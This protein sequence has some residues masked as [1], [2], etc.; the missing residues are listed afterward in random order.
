MTELNRNKAFKTRLLTG[1]AMLLPGVA[2]PLAARIAEDLNFEAL[3]VTGAGVSNTNFGLPD[4]GLTGLTDVANAVICIRSVV[5]LPLVVDAD[6]GFGN[7]VNVYH[8]VRTLEAAGANAIQLEDQDFPKRCGHFEGKSVIASSL[9]VDKIKAAVDARWDSDLQIVART[10]A[11]AVEG[12]EAAIERAQ[13]Y[14]EAG[15]DI[16]FVEAVKTNE[17]MRAVPARLGRPQII[18]IVHGGKTPPLP[19]AELDAMGF[20]LILYA[21]AALQ[22]SIAAMQSVLGELHRTGSLDGVAG[23]LATFAERQR[24]VR[25]DK[26]DAL[27]NRY[28]PI[29][30]VGS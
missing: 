22:A 17:Q 10:D 8:T 7:A 3:Y 19:L 24:I 18:N 15:A 29:G 2:N 21:N 30:P 16:T 1:P 14:I 27:E 13:A 23:E 28:S 20:S 5:N 25:K 6:T 11:F 26:Y 12:F 4:I 9:M